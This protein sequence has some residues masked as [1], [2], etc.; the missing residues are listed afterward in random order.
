MLSARRLVPSV[1]VVVVGVLVFASASALAA[2]PEVPQTLKAEPIGSASATLNGVLNPLNPGEVGSYEFFYRASATECQGEGGEASG[3]SALGAAKEAVSAPAGGL[4]PNTVYTVCLLARNEA[5]ETQ[6]SSPVTFTTLSRKPSVSGEAVSHVGTAGATVSA[7]VD[8]GGLETS[9]SVQYGTTI[10]YGLETSSSSLS[11]GAGTTV[12]LAGL[13]PD[14]EYHARFLVSNADGSNYGDDMTFTT[15]P[16][17]VSSGLPDGRVY[18][19]VSKFGVPFAEVDWPGSSPEGSLFSELPFG[20]SP[21]GDVVTYAGTP[22]VGGSGRGAYVGNE[23]LASRSPTDGWNQVNISPPGDERGRYQ[24]FSSDLSTGAVWIAKILPPFVASETPTELETG[25][26]L[27]G[28]PALYIRTFDEGMYR[29]L[30]VMASH[31]SGESLNVLEFSVGASDI[32]ADSTHILFEANDSLLEGEGGLERELNSNVAQEVKESKEVTA[33]FNEMEALNRERRALEKEGEEE[34]ARIKKQEEEVKSKELEVL[35]ALYVHDSRSELYVSV[36]G[37]LSLVNV[38]PEGRILPG[39]VFGGSHEISA[40]DSRIFWTSEE[41]PD[42]VFVREDGS[43]TVQVSPGPAQFW[44]ASND[45]RYAF[46]TEAGK[47]WRFDVENETRVEIAGSGGGVQSVIGTN[48][49]SEDGAY[50]YFV[51]QEVLTSEA[52]A[53]KQVAV[54]GEDNLYVYEPDPQNPGHSRIAFIAGLSGVPTAYVTPDGQAL[55]F[56]ASQNLTEHPYPDEG[57][58]EVYVYDAQDSSLFCASCRA[59]VSGGNL[60]SGHRWVSDDGNRVFFNSEAPLVASDINGERDVY[61]WE[62]DGSGGCDEENGCVYLLSAG[63]DGAAGLVD[64][65]ASG[66]DVFIATRQRLLPEG[67]NENVELYDARVD[68]TLAI[69]PPECSGTACQGSP[70]PAPVFATPASVTFSGVGNFPPAITTTVRV[71]AKI[72]TRAQKLSRALKQCHK[73]RS[74]KARTACEV[75]ARNKYAV[76]PKVRQLAKREVR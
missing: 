65:S 11:S 35:E 29:P 3:G 60:I 57:S 41:N 59:Q 52:N 6:L 63:V 61:E 46:Y 43:S 18:E 26:A 55:V 12:S 19:L 30:F 67:Q 15:Y 73:K 33:L 36:G 76:K 54:E 2:A 24:V 72:L 49:T 62:R 17:N 69:A 16:V 40:D 71:K 37:K 56:S 75:G 58:E 4:L 23:Y 38:S 10:A 20:T 68:G 14:T 64:A 51:A 47:L 1:F 66:N 27:G 74:R 44:T 50:V 42:A 7:Q 53:A 34:A 32:S 28:S 21:D 25:S 9:Y 22:S 45:G 48:E 39:A 5:G 8:A 31:R 70:A 13:Q